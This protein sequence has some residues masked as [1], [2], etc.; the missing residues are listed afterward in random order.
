MLALRSIPSPPI[1]F[2]QPLAANQNQADPATW[3]GAPAT[4]TNYLFVQ[5]SASVNV[6]MTLIQAVS[7]QSTMNVAANAQA[8]QVMVTTYMNGLLPFSPIAP[9]SGDTTNYG[10][11]AGQLYTLRY[12]SNGGQN[13][14]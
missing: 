14:G 11:Q 5:V 12:P 2:A 3:T 13:A 1:Q 8:G 6:P 10:Y 7:A 9:N 4:G